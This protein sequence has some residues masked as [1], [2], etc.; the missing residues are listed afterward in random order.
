FGIGMDGQVRAAVLDSTGNL[1][2]GWF[3]APAGMFSKLTVATLGNGNI[4]VFAI[5]TNGQVHS[6]TYQA[7]DGMLMSGWMPPSGGMFSDLAAATNTNQRTLLLAINAVNAQLF[8]E[9]VAGANGVINGFAVG[10]AVR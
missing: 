10:P 3:N 5:C 9:L 4:G 6:A 1:T 2:M 8:E 7:S